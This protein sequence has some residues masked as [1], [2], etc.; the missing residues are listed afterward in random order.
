[1]GLTA[2]RMEAEGCDWRQRKRMQTDLSN[3]IVG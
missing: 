3:E 1:M 2:V